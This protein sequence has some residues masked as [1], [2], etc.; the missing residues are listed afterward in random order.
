MIGIQSHTNHHFSSKSYRLLNAIVDPGDEWNGFIGV[1][2]ILLTHAHFDHIYGLNKLMQ[3]NPSAKIYTNDYGKQMLL[4]AKKNLSFYHDEV[5]VLNYPNSVV[6]IRDN[7][8]LKL[9]ENLTAKA[10]Y[11]PGHNPSCITWVIDNSLFTGDAYIPGFKTITN[12]PAGDKKA[13]A[14]SFEI[15]KGL[16]FGRTVYPG[17]ETN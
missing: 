11:T 4:D 6:L 16:T 14:N 5:F 8:E 15:I 1:E 13:A 12:L 10:V 2:K 17:H 7:E 9:D 3:L